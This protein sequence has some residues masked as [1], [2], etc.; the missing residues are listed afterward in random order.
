MQT[1]RWRSARERPVRSLRLLGWLVAILGGTFAVIGL[2]SGTYGGS[3]GFVLFLYAAVVVAALTAAMFSLARLH[4]EIA[5]LR[6]R[7]GAGD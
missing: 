7:L 1:D 6:R 4:Q 5:D 2:V 3:L